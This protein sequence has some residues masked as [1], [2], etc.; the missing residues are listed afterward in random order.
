M[1]LMPDSPKTP[2]SPL[3]SSSSGGGGLAKIMILL[4]SFIAA[5]SAVQLAIAL[6]FWRSERAL[7][8]PLNGVIWRAVRF[9]R[10]AI[11]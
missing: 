7:N 4:E 10:F 8:L 6:C 3:L 9:T 2:D 5:L 1:Q 11:R